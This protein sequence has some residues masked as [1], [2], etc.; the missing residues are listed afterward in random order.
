MELKI[1]AKQCTIPSSSYRKL[2]GHTKKISKSL[3][4]LNDN[5]I[6]YRLVLKAH[7]H[8]YRVHLDKE[9]IPAFVEGAISFRLA[10]K[11]LSI[12]FKGLTVDECLQEGIEKISRELVK[13]KDLHF[14]SQSEYPDRS[15]I[16]TYSFD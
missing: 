10:K 8:R 7:Y 3:S 5:A 15:S 13:Y 16:R 12:K 1:T 4:R 14:K 6:V 2:L 11:T 9:Q